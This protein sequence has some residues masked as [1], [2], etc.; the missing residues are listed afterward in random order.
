M[1]PSFSSAIAGFSVWNG[2]LPGASPFGPPEREKAAPRFWNTTPV[3]G[4]VRPE[5]NS[6]KTL[7]MKLTTVPSASAAPIQ[8]VSPC[9][10]S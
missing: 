10:G 8:I 1:R 7:W 9:F 6:Q 3:S 2:R 5:P 4:Q